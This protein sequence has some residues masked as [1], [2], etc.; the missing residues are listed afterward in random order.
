VSAGKASYACGLCSDGT[1]TAQS[2]RLIMLSGSF[3][4]PVA[5][6]AEPSPK[7]ACVLEVVE[8]TAYSALIWVQSNHRLIGP[9]LFERCLP[10][11]PPSAAPKWEGAVGENKGA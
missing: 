4:R 2:Q 9:R 10:R 6:P 11:P 3:P 5:D 1:S 8:A 7:N